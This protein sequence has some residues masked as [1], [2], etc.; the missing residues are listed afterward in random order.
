MWANAVALWLMI[1]AIDAKNVITG[2]SLG[3]WFEW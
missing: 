1:H 3:E 2:S